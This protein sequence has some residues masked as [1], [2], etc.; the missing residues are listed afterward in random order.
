[1]PPS[2]IKLTEPP[3]PSE[4]ECDRILGAYLR[5]WNQIEMSLASL[6]VHLTETNVNTGLILT[7]SISDWRARREIIEAL[8]SARLRKPDQKKLLE[9][10]DRIHR[11][12]TQRNRIVHGSWTLVITIH[13]DQKGEKRAVIGKWYRADMPA[14]QAKRDEIRTN[15]KVRKQHQFG[16][17]QIINITA[18]THELAKEI[19]EFQRT[20]KLTPYIA[21]QPVEF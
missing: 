14:D 6:L 1:M 17:Q 4:P 8:G 18:S 7:E 20:L 15:P 19:R 16:A 2:D 12:N 21:P 5:A 3:T 13:K 11:A 9:F 10:T